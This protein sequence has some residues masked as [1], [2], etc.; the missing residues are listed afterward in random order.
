MKY[1]L[2][3]DD[4]TFKCDGV[5]ILTKNITDYFN[6]EKIYEDKRYNIDI[7]TEFVHIYNDKR[8]KDLNYL[9]YEMIFSDRGYSQYMLL[10]I[11]E[12]QINIL[13]MVNSLDDTS[14]LKTNHIENSWIIDK[15]SMSDILKLS[16]EHFYIVCDLKQ[17]NDICMCF[18]SQEDKLLFNIVV[19]LDNTDILPSM[20][21][22]EFENSI[23]HIINKNKKSGYNNKIYIDSI[24][25]SLKSY[26]KLIEK[27]D[28]KISNTPIIDKLFYCTLFEQQLFNT[29]MMLRQYKMRMKT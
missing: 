10:D 14:I 8:N 28:I 21:Y 6:L 3:L 27:E 5:Q 9:S 1:L 26:K 7:G 19:Y 2:R 4:N 18:S 23:I 29:E 22:E 12:E 15:I 20:S 16:N 13:N 17:H 11:P 24:I 25:E